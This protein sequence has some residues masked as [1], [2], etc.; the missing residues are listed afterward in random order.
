MKSQSDAE[1]HE[2]S[3]IIAE[4]VYC[5]DMSRQMPNIAIC[6]GKRQL[7]RFRTHRDKLLPLVVFN[8][9][10]YC[11]RELTEVTHNCRY[12]AFSLSTNVLLT[13][14]FCFN[15]SNKLFEMFVF[16]ILNVQINFDHG[17]KYFT[18]VMYEFKPRIVFR[19][20]AHG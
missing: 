9:Y 6:R 18:N 10:H 12:I 13:E 2:K 8:N 19:S 1:N 15:I 4:K 17:I 5:R 16:D 20:C 3:R 14:D 7:S 11:S